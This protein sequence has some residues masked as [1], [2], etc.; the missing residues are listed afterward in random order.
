[1]GFGRRIVP[2]SLHPL[3]QYATDTNRPCCCSGNDFSPGGDVKRG[4]RAQA[5]GRAIRLTNPGSP[6][7]SQAQSGGGVAAGRHLMPRRTVQCRDSCV[8]RHGRHIAVS[9]GKAAPAF[10]AAPARMAN[11][12]HRADLRKVQRRPSGSGD[13]ARKRDAESRVRPGERSSS[14]SALQLL[15]GEAVGA[16]P[17]RGRRRMNAAPRPASARVRPSVPPCKATNARATIDPAGDV[18]SGS[19]RSAK[20]WQAPFS[21]QKSKSL[22]S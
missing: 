5:P 1:M 3:A 12:T 22:P 6:L 19:S 20:R 8:P 10:R 15:Y 16:G 11:G 13:P 9:V 17:T 4:P 2:I 14:C 21:A 18:L 7:A